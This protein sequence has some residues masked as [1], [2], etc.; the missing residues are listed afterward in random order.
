MMSKTFLHFLVKKFGQIQGSN[1]GIWIRQFFFTHK[2]EI[3]VWILCKVPVWQRIRTIE[4]LDPD[5]TVEQNRYVLT[6]K[7]CMEGLLEKGN[8]YL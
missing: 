3:F 4:L 5:E 8:F 1:P 6:F 7:N 2:I